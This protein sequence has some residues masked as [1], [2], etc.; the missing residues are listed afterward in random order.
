MFKP[1]LLLF[2]SNV[3]MTFAWYGHLKDLK[4]APLWIAIA[5]SWAIALLEYCFQVPAN[6]IGI[7]YFTLPQLKVI[8]EVTTMLVFAGFSVAYMQVPITRNYFFAAMLLAGAAYLIF[9]DKPQ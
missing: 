2:I 9:S 6:R 5:V 8:Q 4:T 7:Q 1:I 3:F